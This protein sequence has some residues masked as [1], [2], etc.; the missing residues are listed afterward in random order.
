MA[1]L[2]EVPVVVRDLDPVQQQEIMLVENLQRQDLSPVELSGIASI[3]TLMAQ[4]RLGRL[5]AS[6]LSSR[7]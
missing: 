6:R 4:W 2:A 1:G 7:P 5:R 3:T